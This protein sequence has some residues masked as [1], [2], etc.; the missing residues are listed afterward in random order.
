MLQAA[1]LI[2]ALLQTSTAAAIPPHAARPEAP[3]GIRA[4][5]V[6][7]G[8]RAPEIAAASTTGGT[9]SSSQRSAGRLVL[10]FFRG[11]W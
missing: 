3:P 7:V 10:V 9:W 1:A 4:R 5:A 6:E 11:D 8:K 2:L